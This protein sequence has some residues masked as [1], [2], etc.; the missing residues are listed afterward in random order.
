MVEIDN[1]GTYSFREGDAILEVVNT[2]H[3]GKNIGEEP[4]KLVVIYTGIEGSPNTVKV[5]MKQK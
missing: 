3:I 5:T 1:G 4:V 2:P